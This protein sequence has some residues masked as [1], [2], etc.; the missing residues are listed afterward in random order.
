M[1]VTLLVSQVK[2]L[3][4]S[5]VSDGKLDTSEILKI[6]IAVQGLASSVVGLSS[7]EKK[8]LVV[9][10]VEKALKVH[11]PF[12]VLDE[13]GVKV[14]LQL[15]PTV[16]D[17]AVKAVASVEPVK[18]CFA[19]CFSAAKTGALAPC[20]VSDAKKAEPVEPVEVGLQL[21]QPVSG[22]VTPDAPPSPPVET[23]VEHVVI[24]APVDPLP[25]VEETPVEETLVEE[26]P[27]K[28]IDS[29][30]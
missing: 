19:S 20:F 15:L 16:L 28:T 30:L 22:T 13:A 29:D 8:G 23:V 3:V 24:E 26:T 2:D 14:A 12:A 1:T 11:I 18:S 9:K 25:P 17:I 21:L 5:S 27:V 6:A 7:D 10:V 4:V